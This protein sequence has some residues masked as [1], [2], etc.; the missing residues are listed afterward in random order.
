MHIVADIITIGVFLASIPFAFLKKNVSLFAFRISLILQ[1]L[2]RTALIT[3]V[4]VLLWGAT[5]IYY[6]FILLAFKGQVNPE[7]TWFW[8]DGKEWQHILAYLIAYPIGLSLAW[9]ICTA[10]WTSSWNLAK[11]FLNALVPGKLL[12]KI[13]Q[14][15]T[16]EIL[17]ALY[18]SPNSEIDVTRI[19]RLMVSNNKLTIQASN[20]LGGDPEPFQPK[21]LFIKYRIGQQTDTQEIRE[22]STA[23]IPNE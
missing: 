6:F 17:S 21:R 22:G 14:E 7:T 13:Q 16:L 3:L 12:F 23:T 1:Y 9:I 2:L 5:N 20:E 4:L 15:P 18:V 19:V 10:I 11:L 8:E